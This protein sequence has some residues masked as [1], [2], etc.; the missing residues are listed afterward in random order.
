MTR[1]TPDRPPRSPSL[2]TGCAL[3]PDYQR[4]AVP[5]PRDLARDPAA[6][7]QSFA[8][9]AWWKLFDDP[10]LQE[11]D[12]D[13]PRR[14]QGPQ[15]RRRA[16]RGGAGPLRLHQGRPLA[17]DRPRPPVGATPEPQRERL[18]PARRRRRR[19]RGDVYGLSADLSW[20]L[21]FFGRIRRTTEAQMALLLGTEEARRASRAGP[22][23]RRGARPT[24]SCA[25]LDRSSRSPA[26]RIESRREYVQLARD[27][28]EGG[29]TPE[30]D[31]RQ[32][33]AELTAGRGG[34]PRPRATVAAQGE[35]AVGPPRPQPRPDPARS[36]AST[37]MTVPAAVP[38]GLPSELLE[39]RPDIREAEQD[40]AAAT[41]N[42]GAAKALL[43]PRIA[44]TGSLGFA[45]TDVDN[46]VRRAE[47]VLEP[48][49][50][51]CCSRS[52]TPARTGAG[53]R[54]RS[55]SSG[56]PSTATRRRCCRPSA[57][58]RTPSSP[59]GRPASSGRPQADRVE[60]ERKV[61]EL[62]E[63]RYRGGVADY[64][65]VLDAQRS[66]FDAELDEAQTIGANLTSLVRLYKALGGGWNPARAPGGD[67]GRAGGGGEG[68]LQLRKTPP[69]SP[70]GGG[71]TRSARRCERGVRRRPFRALSA[72]ARVGSAGESKERR[73]E[74]NGRRRRR[75]ARRGAAAPRSGDRRL[76]GANRRRDLR[77]APA[78]DPGP[79]TRRS[80]SPTPSDSAG[81][82][83]SSCSSSPPRARS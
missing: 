67:A 82:R 16:G 79:G 71:G 27:R 36:T 7:A 60:A 53:W 39:R 41:A 31:Y 62:A 8:N 1:T 21:D 70:G 72:A 74:R 18:Q 9:T 50:A 44:L 58:P 49:S 54:S 51:A 12:R 30:I 19:P 20:E 28:F 11:L 35:R 81:C 23:R 38:A 4:P 33:E 10:A 66:L 69:P 34:R 63:L 65:E 48:R 56:R 2:A 14:E 42:I 17:E 22:R 15:D 25:T 55:R 57:R 47:P 77:P 78:P 29:I 59:T 24:S 6:E 46:A 76:A 43:F 64:L 5:A 83:S 3:G 32:A 68:E 73:F 37:S 13:R 75:F 26:A 40:L 80:A 52:S 45:S 61:L